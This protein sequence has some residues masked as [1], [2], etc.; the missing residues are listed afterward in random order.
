M[1]FVVFVS[2]ISV[3]VIATLRELRLVGGKVQNFSWTFSVNWG[4]LG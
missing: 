3:S 2:H 1:S 4:E